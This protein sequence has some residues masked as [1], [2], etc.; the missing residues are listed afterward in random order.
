MT[1]LDNYN[2]NTNDD[3][4]PSPKGTKPFPFVKKIR[5][6]ANRHPTLIV[7]IP[8]EICHL[9]ELNKGDQ[10]NVCCE[11]ENG[12]IVMDKIKS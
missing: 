6:I 3:F 10:F 2:M 8:Y 12:R 5:P 9:L 11:I 7:S 4:I 1:Y